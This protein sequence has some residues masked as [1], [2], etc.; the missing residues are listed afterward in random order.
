[1][2][3]LRDQVRGDG[4]AKALG[5]AGH[6]GHLAGEASGSGFAG[7]HLLPV[8][9]GF[10]CFDEGSFRGGK[11]AYATQQQRALPDP[12]RVEVDVTRRV[13]LRPAVATR[14]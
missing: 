11:R 3:T 12:Q 13:R 4:E 2:A 10:P 6:D 9:L 7:R 8:R 1:M 14:R 5:G